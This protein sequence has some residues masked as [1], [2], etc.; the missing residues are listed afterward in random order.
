MFDHSGRDTS[1][2]DGSR[3]G[4]SFVED[5][6]CESEAQNAANDLFAEIGDGRDLRVCCRAIKGNGVPEVEL[7]ENID[8]G[9]IIFGLQGGNSCQLVVVYFGAGLHSPSRSHL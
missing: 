5:M 9:E 3:V 7:I 1:V 4:T 2:D 6:F 8:D